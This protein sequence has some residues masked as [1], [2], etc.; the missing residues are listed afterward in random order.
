MRFLS[1]VFTLLLL[2]LSAQAQDISLYMRIVELTVEKSQITKFKAA[3]REDIDAAVR[4]ED[5]ALEI[6]AVYDKQDSGRVIVIETFSSKEDHSS[7]QQ[8]NHYLKFQ[9]VAGEW[10]KSVN[11]T[12]VIPFALN[13]KLQQ[14]L[15]GKKNI[16]ARPPAT[17]PFG[18]EAF[19]PSDKTTIRWLGNAGFLINS[20]GTTFMVDPLMQGFDMPI[21]IDI[22]ISPQSIPHLD[23]V[24]VTHSDNDHYSIPTLKELAAVTNAFHSTVYVDSLMKNQGFKSFGYEIDDQFKVDNITITLTPADHSWQNAYPGA[25]DRFFR[26]EDCTGFLIETPDGSIWVTG[27]SRLMDEHLNMKTP[28]VILFDFSDSEWH[29]TLE[30]AIK[31]ANTYPNTPLLLHHWGTIDAPD[32]APFNGDPEDLYGTVINPERI[33]LLAPG[34]PFDLKSLKNK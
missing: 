4:L 6:Y 21:M 26:Q 28:D 24:L 2:T 20:R 31:L 12:E 17:Q 18:G 14:G 13:S 7:H 19:E 8:T 27:D 23:A 15:I 29:F 32:F 9:A 5:G 33:V 11:R 34:E 3:L 16:Q 22:P 25:S 10:V 1:F 30:G